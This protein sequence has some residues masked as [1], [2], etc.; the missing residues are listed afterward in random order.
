[1]IPIVSL[2]AA[3]LM[4]S[5]NLKALNQVVEDQETDHV[6]LL[7]H[8]QSILDLNEAISRL[9]TDGSTALVKVTALENWKTTVFTPWKQEVDEYINDENGKGAKKSWVRDNFAPIDHTHSQYAEIT[10]VEE[11]FQPKGEYASQSDYEAL[12]ARVQALE[13]AQSGS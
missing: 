3:G 9:G 12:L 6:T 4:T 2:G 8:T 13:E 7:N 5:D 11:N 1:M 10:W